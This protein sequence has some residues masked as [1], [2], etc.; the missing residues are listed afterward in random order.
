M[1]GLIT[2]PAPVSLELSPFVD[3]FGLPHYSVE[4]LRDIAA[5]GFKRVGVVAAVMVQE[6]TAPRLLMLHHKPSEKVAAPGA[7]GPMAET[8]RVYDAPSGRHV[9]SAAATIYRS[10]EEETGMQARFLRPSLPTR[11]IGAYTTCK[12]PVGHA[13]Q[14]SFAYGV[15]PFLYLRNHASASQLVDSFAETEEIDGA[16]FMEPDEIRETSLLRPGTLEWLAV[17]ENSASF[18]IAGP[19]VDLPHQPRVAERGQDVILANLNL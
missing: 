15:V 8:S 4:D 13:D 3:R 10:F 11:S 18:D 14:A 12:W 1:Q 9:E 6:R 5:A 7:W 19:F 16:K 17:V 2:P